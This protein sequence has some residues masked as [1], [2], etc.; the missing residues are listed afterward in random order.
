MLSNCSRI[1]GCAVQKD[2]ARLSRLM[3]SKISLEKLILSYQLR[4]FALQKLQQSIQIILRIID[5]LYLTAVILLFNFYR[6]T[7]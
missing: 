2:G 4:N 1:N 3:R 6:G 7:I 5:E